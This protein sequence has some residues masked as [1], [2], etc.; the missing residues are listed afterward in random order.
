ML[1]AIFEN[2]RI[3]ILVFIFSTSPTFNH[4]VQFIKAPRRHCRRS[5]NRNMHTSGVIDSLHSTLSIT[6]IM[7]ISIVK[8]GFIA[9]Q[10]YVFNV[11]I[12]VKLDI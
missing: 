4:V 1:E 6:Y 10:F 11:S 2:T 7:K 9:T 8:I 3:N 12:Y 5:D